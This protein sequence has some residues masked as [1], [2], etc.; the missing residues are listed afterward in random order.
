MSSYYN[1]DEYDLVGFEKSNEKYKKY[2][3]IL[4]NKK[5][6]RKVRV[7]FGDIRYEQYKDSTPL[8]LYS[9]LNHNDEKRRAS[10]RAR[11]SVFI[12]DGY[13]SPGYFAYKFLW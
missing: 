3:A 4:R 1:M 8:K 5:T 10:Y 2:A 9:H 12:K 13:Y 11:H 7:N 6:K